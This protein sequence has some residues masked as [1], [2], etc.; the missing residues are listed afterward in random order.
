MTAKSHA[1]DESVLFAEARH[2]LVDND[3]RR[4]TEFRRE[5][6]PHYLRV[7]I[8]ITMIWFIIIATLVGLFALRD[9]E[10]SILR[11]VLVG[12]SSVVLG[13]SFAMLENW[14]HE[15][16]H[17][18][19]H[20]EREWN[21]RSANFFL[22]FIICQDIKNYRQV[23]F[24]HHRYLGK[25]NDPERS[26]FRPLNWQF[27]LEG[28]LGISVLKA[29]SARADAL[30]KDKSASIA[31][32]QLLGGIFLNGSVVLGAASQGYL[33]V[34]IGWTLGLV[35]VYPLAGSL[36]QLLEHRAADLSPQTDFSKVEHG[37]YSRSFGNGILAKLI[38]TA[39]FN[40]HLLH[41]WEP[42]LSCTRFREM[43]N[44]I[45]QTELA[46]IYRSRSTT[47]S[48]TFRNLFNK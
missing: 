34:S 40:Q 21:D 39:G 44:F 17:Y 2:R 47:Y 7:W 16:S 35:S 38:G 6:Q 36:R 33:E 25:T 42:Q 28:L 45:L 27:I 8:V 1:G 26:Y 4:F 37:P 10:H 29:L 32:V 12:L 20:P 14:F 43:E 11:A 5:L 19:I 15:A 46:D 24:D 30:P 41:H 13:I 48:D 18:N 9:I 23:H 22:G 31:N 3:G